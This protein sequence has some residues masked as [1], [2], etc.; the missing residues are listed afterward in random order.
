MSETRTLKPPATSCAQAPSARRRHP[1]PEQEP[2]RQSDGTSGRGTCPSP[3]PDSARESS[4][5]R[6]RPPPPLSQSSTV[7]LRAGR[8]LCGGRRKGHRP[9]PFHRTPEGTDDTN[10]PSHRVH[11]S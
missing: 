2:S 1:P 4:K 7:V 11:V 10:T 3:R 6:P 9:L 8:S 5:G